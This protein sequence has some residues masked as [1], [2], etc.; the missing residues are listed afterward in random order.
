[1]CKSL[2]P[3]FARAA[4]RLYTL[5]REFGKRYE[6]IVEEFEENTSKIR[7]LYPEIKALEERKRNLENDLKKL[8]ERKSLEIAKI[9]ELIKGVENLQRIGAEKVCRLS[10]FV[11]EFEKH[12]YSADELAKIAR[13]VDKRIC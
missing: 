8:E 12:G 6:E 7:K 5:E 11:E 4:V 2:S 1:M 13:F 3:E 10:T 9:E